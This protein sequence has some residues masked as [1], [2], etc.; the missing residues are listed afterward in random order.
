MRFALWLIA[1]AGQTIVVALIAAFFLA[2][3]IAFAAV[4]LPGVVDLL[5]TVTQ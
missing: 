2:V 3:G 4:V 1:L 5:L